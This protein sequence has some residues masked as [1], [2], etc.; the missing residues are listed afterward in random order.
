MN[1][2]LVQDRVPERWIKAAKKRVQRV[3]KAIEGLDPG[4]KKDKDK[5]PEHFIFR[6]IANNVNKAPIGSTLYAYIGWLACWFSG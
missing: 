4:V 6:L 1:L 5:A 3:S 2:T